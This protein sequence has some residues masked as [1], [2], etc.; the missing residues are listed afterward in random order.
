M[1]QKDSFTKGLAKGF[2]L[3]IIHVSLLIGVPVYMLQ[4][5]YDIY[6]QVTQNPVVNQFTV[7]GMVITLLGIVALKYVVGAF[8]YN[9]NINI[10]K[11]I[12]FGVSNAIPL[13]LVLLF[14]TWLSDNIEF[15]R[16][17]LLYTALTNSIAYLFAPEFILNM[18][19]GRRQ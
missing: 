16:D 19:D 10:V 6:E 13:V 18:K 1:E 17:I 3:T 2:I 11:K 15:L 12:W 8:F 4:S 5:R 9:M 14:A 7:S